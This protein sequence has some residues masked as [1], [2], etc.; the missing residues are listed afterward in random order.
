MT[1]LKIFHSRFI[2]FLVVGIAIFAVFLGKDILTNLD[3][4]F[5]NKFWVKIISK[6][7]VS[8]FLYTLLFYG[9]EFLIQKYLWRLIK[10][11]LD[12]SGKW[13]GITY[14][15]NLKIPSTKVTFKNFKRFSS[16]HDVV[17]SQDSL[18]IKIEGSKG[19][20][21]VGWKSIAMNI[22][23]EGIL[24]FVYEVDYEK[25][26]KAEGCNLTGTS[27]GYEYMRPVKRGFLGLPILLSGKFYHCAT[28]KKPIYSGSTI[29]VRQN[30]LDKIS[31]SDLPGF[32]KTFIEDIK[33][34][35][36][37]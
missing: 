13:I 33:K 29:F 9:G 21:Y 28:D 31:E 35:I 2:R 8:S 1:E 26:S 34:Y 5:I 7:A 17:I 32:G 36:N 3:S 25:K 16:P 30:H 37:G 11:K 20:D 19:D 14:Y 4:Y 10:R 18:T 24:K 23:E 6:I 22:D 12:Y 15:T 27:I